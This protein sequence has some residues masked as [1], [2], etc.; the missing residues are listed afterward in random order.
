[1]SIEKEISEDSDVYTLLSDPLLI[2]LNGMDTRNTISSIQ[3]IHQ[4]EKYIH[5]TLDR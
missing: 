4:E 1:M 5:L 3:L 2:S